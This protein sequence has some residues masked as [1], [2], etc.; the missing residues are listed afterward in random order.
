MRRA[1]E[2]PRQ[3]PDKTPASVIF[4]KTPRTAERADNK[5]PLRNRERPHSLRGQE[6][7]AV[8]ERHAGKAR[9]QHLLDLRFVEPQRGREPP[10]RIRRCGDSS[11]N[12]RINRETYS[13]SVEDRAPGHAKLRREA[14]E[15]T[16]ERLTDRRLNLKWK[17]HPPEGCP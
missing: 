6:I 3:P 12:C 5:H 2:P 9:K 10:S 7:A 1:C 13:D 8:R 14:V 16:R 15:K 4:G 17:P 11:N